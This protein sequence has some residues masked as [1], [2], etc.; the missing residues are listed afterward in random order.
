[1]TLKEVSMQKWNPLET[2]FPIE[3]LHPG[4]PYV[5]ASHHPHDTAK[6]QP[7]RPGFS[8]PAQAGC[9]FGALDAW[10]RPTPISGSTDL[11]FSRS[12]LRAAR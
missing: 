2:N 5:G 7:N 4:R 11:H 9:K 3:S 12:T 10:P 8:A 6:Q 1:M